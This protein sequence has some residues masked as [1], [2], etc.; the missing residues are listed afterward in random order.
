MRLS[1][2]LTLLKQNSSSQAAPFR[3]FLVCGFTPLHL[4]TFLSAHLG[5]ALPQRRIEVET[6]LYGDFSG[7]LERLKRAPADC[8]VVVLEWADLD[9][10][11]GIRGLGG[12]RVRD[13]TGILDHVEKRLNR[14]A[15]AIQS[16]SKRFPI[17]VCLPTLPVPPIQPTQ[18]GW[19]A[20]AFDFQLRGCL[21]SFASRAAANPGV[22]MVNPEWLD[23]ISPPADR[24]DVKSEVSSGFPFKLPHADAFAGLL[25]LLVQGRAPRKG[26]ITDL[27]CT[28]WKGILGEIGASQIFWD[29]DHHSH[30]HG[31]YQELLRSLA[32]SGVLI[33]VASKNDPAQVEEA[34][35]RP[36][37]ILRREH[38]FPFEVHWNAK[39]GSVARILDA[40]N[41]AADSVVF[42]DDSPA[43]LAEVQAAHPEIECLQFP[44]DPQ[45]VYQL[46]TRLRNLFAKGPA[47]EEDALRLASIRSMNHQ[48]SESG[49]SGPTA[50]E[51]L[52]QAESELTFS[53]SKA[54]WDARVLELINKTNQF[55]LNGV[56]YTEIDL[57]RFIAH[58]DAFLLKASYQDKF[59]PLGK[60]AVVLGRTERQTLHV[61]SWVMSCRAFSRRIEHECLNHLLRT[62]D[63]ER[64]QFE[65]IGT[66]RNKPLQDFLA[67][68]AGTAPQP[69]LSIS[70]KMFFEKCPRL[71]HRVQEEVNG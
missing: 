44:A 43:E 60:I 20:G 54:P 6:G 23:L 12:W 36:D 8:G 27:D 45:E 34:F 59:G 21:Y 40:W 24:L 13:F 47:T 1:E 22:K 19:Q 4:Q 3:V 67:G 5:L 42:V 49:A 32:A 41:I 52:E 37:L 51:F 56:R 38:V 15:A 10:R 53:L 66:S 14:I 9:A 2:A 7:N 33:G 64:I 17:A 70:K 69:G 62:F 50:D 39:S 58:P 30:M 16:I 25:A 57:R 46:I 65:F 11:L 55:N 28:L 48:L 18:A 71:F 63:V 35:N 68:I 31:M 29:L 61:Q 26:L